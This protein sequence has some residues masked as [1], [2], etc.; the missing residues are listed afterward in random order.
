YAPGFV[1]AGRAQTSSARWRISTVWTADRFGRTR[2]RAMRNWRSL[3]QRP[4]GRSTIDR[5]SSLKK[6][7]DGRGQFHGPDDEHVELEKYDKRHP[8]G[9]RSGRRSEHIPS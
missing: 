2:I 9:W 1:R 8:P 5:G 4:D 3:S 7:P 6:P